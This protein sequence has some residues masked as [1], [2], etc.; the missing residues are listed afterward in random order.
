M[1]SFLI[2]NQFS[3]LIGGVDEAGRGPLAGPVVAA[4]VHIPAHFPFL[5]QV[6]DS[7]KLNGLQREALFTEITRQCPFGIAIADVEEI[8]SINILQ[9]TFLAMSRAVDALHVGFGITLNTV[10]VDGNQRPRGLENHDVHTVVEGDDKS[11]SIACASILAKVTRD[12]QMR[13]I[14]REYPQYGWDTNMGYGTAAHLS[15]L[16]AHGPCPHHRT[17]FTPVRNRLP[18]PLKKQRG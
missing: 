9:A 14:A 4:C 11:Y 18:A 17:S 8:D 10:L 5:D 15:A 16:D 2:E 13:E 12:R 7:K 6:K 3:G 1:P